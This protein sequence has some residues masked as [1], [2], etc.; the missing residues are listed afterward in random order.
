[1][2]KLNYPVLLL[3]PKYVIGGISSPK[4]LL[5]VGEINFEQGCFED[6]TIIDAS[7]YE[8]R[9]LSA[10][11][12]KWTWNPWN[13]FKVYRSIW[14]NLELSEP[15]KHNLDHIREKLLNVLLVHPKWY[16]RYSETEQSLRKKLFDV[17]TVKELIDSISIYP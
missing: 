12:I 16:T 6:A 14:V 1:M 17:R 4:K 3:T 13:L 10:K 11:K 7:G 9:V 5:V 15:E 2:P 8:Y